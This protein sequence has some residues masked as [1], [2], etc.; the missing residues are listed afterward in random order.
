MSDLRLPF[1]VWI[2]RDAQAP[3]SASARAP[4]HVLREAHYTIDC[5][6]CGRRTQLEKYQ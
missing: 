5:P 3:P 1:W 4:G 2:D 6:R